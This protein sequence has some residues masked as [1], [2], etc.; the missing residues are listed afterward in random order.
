[1]STH[2]IWRVTCDGPHCANTGI[3]DTI[4][5][6]PDGW[7]RVTSTDHLADWK[8]R[9]RVRSA[10]TGRSHIDQRS[11]WDVI[12][13]SFAL[14]LCPDHLTVFDA[15]LP[16]TEGYAMGARERERRVQVGC[17]CGGL[18]TATKDLRWV[19]RDPMPN[20]QVERTWWQHLPA[21]L[22]EYATRGRLEVAA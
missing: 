3:I 22:R 19:G 9:Q 1:M 13:G 16:R 20:G 12:A 11:R 6:S 17:S 21:G 10:S 4:T 7:R 2:T 5:D 14:H 15:H 8:P 18:S